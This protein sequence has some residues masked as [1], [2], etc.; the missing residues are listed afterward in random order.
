MMILRRLFSVCTLLALAAC[1]GGGGNTSPFGGSAGGGGGT[2]PPTST[3]PVSSLVIVLSAATLANNSTTPVTATVT[4][5]DANNNAISG[6]A[7]TLAANANAVVTVTTGA[8]TNT[9]GQLLATVSYGSDTTPRAVTLTATAG[10]VTKTATLQVISS[11]S[12]Q[13]AAIELIASAN[14]VGTGGDTITIQAFVKD[15][16]NNAL[17]NAPVVFNSSTGTL[18]SVSSSTNASGVAAAT[19]AAG[20]NK[21]NR[22]ATISVTA[23]TVTASLTIPIVDTKL[24]LS[25][26]SSVVT[27]NTKPFTVIATDSKGNA[28]A[29]AT[30]TGTS[31]LGNAIT[32][33]GSAV[34]D[35]SGRIVFNYVATTAGT[36]SGLRFSGLGAQVSPTPAFVVSG[37]DFAFTSPDPAVTTSVA[38]GTSQAVSVRYRISG[39]P[40][41]NKVVSFSATGGSIL[42]ASSTVTDASGVATVNVQSASAGPLTVQASIAGVATT[43]SLQLSIV[44]TTP[45]TLTLQISPTALPV[46]STGSGSNNVAQVIAKL[47]DANFNP[48]AGQVVNFTRVSDPSGGNLLQA[49]STTDSTGTAVV[50]YRAGPQSTANNGVVLSATAAAFPAVTNTATLTVNQ[51]ALFITLGTGNVID[52]LDPQTY[53]KDWVV[54]VTDS[55]GVAVN[56]VNLTMKFLPQYY[57]TGKLVWDGTQYAYGSPIYECISEDRNENGILDLSPVVVSGVTYPNE[58]INGDGTLTP[59]NVVAVTPPSVQTANGRATVSL[60]YA[61]SMVPWINA[62]LTASATVAGTESRRDA[63]FVIV[64]SAPDFT[65]Q[66]NPPAGLISPFGLFPKPSI[67]PPPNVPVNGK[68]PTNQTCVRIQ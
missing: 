45:S 49:S 68:W 59:G 7:V 46:N 67:D 43:A 53:K 40:Q 1:G 30:V 37:D 62:R 6:A 19:F 33:A 25:G 17:A 31:S 18:S 65:Q 22:N 29:G 48:V 3:T 64:G 55:N 2:T 66:T 57:R 12:A 63:D 56:G 26:P 34:T 39:V 50:T 21:A 51:A 44:A 11:A 58:D 28:I 38:V 36:D 16:S 42:P 41:A 27:G 15:G 61:E 54:Y 24:Q 35:S 60:I 14:S 8:T 4:A 47:L 32:P 10:S 9:S 52:N 23:Q 13:P 5:L 20:A